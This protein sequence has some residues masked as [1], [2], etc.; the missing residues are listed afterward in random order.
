MELAIWH[1]PR[2]TK[3]RQ[4]L[5]LIEAAGIEPTVRLYLEEPPSPAELAETLTL[6]GLAPWELA[7]LNEPLAREIGLNELPRD[8]D[9]R[10][11]WIRL[12][13]ANSKVIERP[14][15]IRDDGRAVV[16]RPP[17]NVEELLG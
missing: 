16:G 8:D 17:E 6:L 13:S 3:S 15:V 12:M 2:C 9:T 1:N 5:A 11:E 7:R 4:T 10:E 14:V